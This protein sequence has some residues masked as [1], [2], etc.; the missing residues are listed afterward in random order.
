M[1]RNKIIIYASNHNCKENTGKFL[2]QKEETNFKK[3]EQKSLYQD[4]QGCHYITC[5]HHG[6]IITRG[7]VVGF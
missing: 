3:F 7:K 4:Q 5:A 2:L 1:K 6:V